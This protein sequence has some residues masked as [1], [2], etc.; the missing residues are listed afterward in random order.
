MGVDSLTTPTFAWYYSA[1]NATDTLADDILLSTDQTLTVTDVAL[2]DEGYYYCVV[3]ND[4][5]TEVPTETAKLA[6]AQLLAHWTLD[7]ADYVN[8]QYQDVSGKGHHADPNGTPSFVSGQLGEGINILRADGSAEPTTESWAR[9][10]TWNPS[11]LSGMLTV[12]FW[13]KWAGQNT[14]DSEQVIV[15]KRS[16]DNLGD[17]TQWQ[18]TRPGSNSNKDLWFQSSN[19]NIQVS[20][21]LTK[22]EWQQVT[23]TFDGTTG[24][25]YNNGVAVGSGAFQLGSTEAA[26]NAMIN[27]GG[28]NFDNNASRWMNGVLDDVKIYNYALSDLEVAK[29]YTT[30]NPGSSVCVQSL[31]PDA[32]LD[33]NGDCIVN[34][35]DFAMLAASWLDCG[36]VPD[37]E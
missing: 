25:M 20:N 14:A 32:S 17:A 37:C 33:L 21:V 15:S 5:D 27:L 35:G 1:D 19:T 7:Q 12:S 6:I 22:D 2:T 24:V 4:S 36:L 8:N 18:I 9:A 11:E 10:G 26:A 30:D 34:L 29:M 23:V 31:K 3:K 28:S 16:S 13:L